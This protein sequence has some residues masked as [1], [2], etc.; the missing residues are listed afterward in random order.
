MLEV[1]NRRLEIL[2]LEGLGL[3]EPEI[4]KQLSEKY[5]CSQRTVYGDFECRQ[6]WQPLLQGIMCPN[7]ILLKIINRYEEIYRQASRKMLSSPNLLAQI[8]ALNVMLKANS[9]MFETAVLPGLLL[10]LKELEDK[11]KKGVFVP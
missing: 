1:V 4:V 7:D 9:S 2:K 10:R 3:S 5:G 6:T 11:A 8:A